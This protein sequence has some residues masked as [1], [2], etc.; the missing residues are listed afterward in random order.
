MENLDRTIKEVQNYFKTKL[1][2]GEFDI[3]NIDKYILTAG[4]DNYTFYLWIG[5]L[6]VPSAMRL[7]EGHN[8]VMSLFLS[9]SEQIRLTALVRPIV[10]KR[11]KTELLV[12]KRKELADLE[13]EIERGEK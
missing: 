8:S 12:E 11:L 3:L 6:H 10:Q 4:I 1:L 13:A 5:N 7:Y 9:L 2:A